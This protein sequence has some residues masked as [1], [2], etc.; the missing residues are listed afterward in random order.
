[1]DFID[2][3]R[4]LLEIYQ[5][6]KVDFAFI[7]GFALQAAGVTRATSD[8]DFLIL[9]QDMGKIKPLLIE[10]GYKLVHESKDSVHFLGETPSLGRLDFLLAHRKYAL[11]MLKRAHMK[12][13]FGGQFKFKVIV[14]ED[15]IGLKIQAIANSAH[16]REKDMP[17]IKSLLRLHRDKMDMELVREYYQ[18]FDMEPELDKLLKEVSDEA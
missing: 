2:V 13:G 11:E 18:I 4:F 6:E 17:D 1:M 15:I 7:G 3:L 16:R 9:S 12:E 5:K 10:K 8:V 14:P